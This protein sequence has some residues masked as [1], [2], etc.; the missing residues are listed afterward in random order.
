MVER[1]GGG[2]SPLPTFIATA[3]VAQDNLDLTG[4]V[5]TV[6]GGYDIF[7]QVTLLP[8]GGG[9]YDLCIQPDGLTTNQTTSRFFHSAGSITTEANANDL[10]IGSFTGGANGVF[11][12]VGRLSGVVPNRTGRLWTYKTFRGDVLTH[13]GAGLWTATVDFSFLRFT[14]PGQAGK[15]VAGSMVTAVATGAP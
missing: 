11:T 6:D 12:F 9:V 10:R 8:P 1:G 14:V 13:E 3:L 4:L 15:V 7:G 2:G 5:P